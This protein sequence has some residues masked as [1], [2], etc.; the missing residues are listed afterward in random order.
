MATRADSGTCNRTGGGRTANTQRRYV[1][2]ETLI[3]IERYSGSQAA[4]LRRL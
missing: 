1:E 4:P 2:I 3:W